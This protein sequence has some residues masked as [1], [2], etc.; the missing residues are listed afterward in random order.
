M[1]IPGVDFSGGSAGKFFPPDLKS[2]PRPRRRIAELLK[3]A[4]TSSIDVENLESSRRKRLDLEFMRSPLEIRSRNERIKSV[5]MQMQI[6]AHED[7]RFSPG[8]KVASAADPHETDNIDTDLVFRSIGYKAAALPGLS[9]LGIQF[10]HVR[11]TIPNEGGRVVHDSTQPGVQISKPLA[12]LYVAGWVKRGP[13]GVI[14]S[15]MEDAF[16]TAEYLCQD[17]NTG[18]SFL[19]GAV[20]QIPGE[21]GWKGVQAELA[22]LGIGHKRIDWNGWKTIDKLERAR[23]S[24]LQKPREKITSVEEMKAVLDC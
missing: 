1:N 3:K 14:A 21:G 8:A 15:T 5:T 9:D 10:D 4:A 18:K 19:H 23:G 17:L 24:V 13:T 7:D 22:K 12:G 2:L 11:G 6:F 20:G 16:N